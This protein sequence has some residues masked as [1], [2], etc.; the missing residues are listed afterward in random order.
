MD[1]LY[2]TYKTKRKKQKEMKKTN[3]LVEGATMRC[4]ELLEE[5]ERYTDGRRLREMSLIS[6]HIQV[7]A[8]KPMT[9]LKM[10][11]PHGVVC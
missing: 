4:V 11:R 5:T 2:L 7:A 6:V 10:M 8:A 9:P 1:S 3:N